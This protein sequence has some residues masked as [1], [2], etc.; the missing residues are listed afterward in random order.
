[1]S[2]R[3]DTDLVADIS[4]AARR[5]GEYI[6]GINFEEFKK[7]TKT[8]DAVVRNIEIVGEAVKRLSNG[9]KRMHPDVPWKHMAGMRD[10]II[11]R[12]FGVAID[13]VWRVATKDLPEAIACLEER[14]PRKH[15]R[16]G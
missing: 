6:Q 2:E 11:H 9:F 10:V 8:Q 12:Y 5:I 16:A 1:M 13:I 3:A 15:R 14:R 7:D 4:N